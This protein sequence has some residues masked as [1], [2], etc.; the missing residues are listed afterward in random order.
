MDN[1]YKCSKCPCKSPQEPDEWLAGTHC[2]CEC[3]LQKQHICDGGDDFGLV[4]CK[5]CEKEMLKHLRQSAKLEKDTG[6]FADHLEEID[7]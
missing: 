5:K 1:Y 6:T 3:H 4:D 2:D 7:R